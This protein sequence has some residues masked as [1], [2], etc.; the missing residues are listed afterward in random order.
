MKK[1]HLYCA[2]LFVLVFLSAKAQTAHESNNPDIVPV[3]PQSAI[4]Q[5][6][7]NHQVSE[8]TGIPEITIPLYE[9]ELKGMKIPI[10]LS[11]HASGV[12]AIQYDGD[13]GAGWSINVGGFKVMRTIYGLE[14]EKYQH[15]SYSNWQSNY[16]GINDLSSNRD[17]NEKDRQLDQFTYAW[18]TE[19]DRF[20]YILPSS[21]G[22]FIV[23]NGSDSD[24]IT[25]LIAESQQDKI[26]FTNGNGVYSFRDLVITDEQGVVYY[27]GDND[28]REYAP[29]PL[30]QTIGWP[31]LK[32]ITTYNEE[33]KF[34][35]KG[36]ESMLNMSRINSLIYQEAPFYTNYTGLMENPLQS[37]VPG[38]EF[39]T[40]NF[41]DYEYTGSQLISKITTPYCKVLFV[42]KG[43]PSENVYSDEIRYRWN[44]LITAVEVYNNNNE[45]VKSIN[46][47]YELAQKN[48]SNTHN[49][50]K[51]MTVSGIGQTSAK[52]VFQ[53]SYYPRNNYSYSDMWGYG[54]NSNYIDEFFKTYPPLLYKKYVVAAPDEFKYINQFSLPNGLSFGDRSVKNEPAAEYSLKRITFPTGGFTE[55]DYEPHVDD[56]Q[57]KIGGLRVKRIISKTSET[58]NPII[59]EFQYSKARFEVLLGNIDFLE[60]IYTLYFWTNYQASTV[61][62]PATAYRG[63]RTTNFHINPVLGEILSYRPIYEKVTTLQYDEGQRKYNGKT[64]SVYGNINFY[65]KRE[66]SGQARIL[67]FMGDN[68]IGQI[69]EGTFS[70]NFWT[71]PYLGY[72]PTL[73]SRTYYDN[74]D[75]IK[76][77]ETYNYSNVQKGTFDE[78]RVKER[79]KINNTAELG[80]YGEYDF[81][82]FRYDYI[83]YP[84]K[85]GFYRLDGKVT[86]DY[87]D[88]GEVR[89]AE[90]YQYN[91]NH[92]LIKKTIGN[93]LS[94]SYKYPVDFTE[95]VYKNMVSA[96]IL[97]PVIESVK[98]PDY[99]FNTESSRNKT[100]YEHRN[101]MYLPSS[102]LSKTPNV[103]Y[104]NEIT[105]DRHDAK[106]NI[107]QCTVLDGISIVYL[108]S[109]SGQYPIA[110]IKNATYSQ[111]TN[112]INETTLNLISNRVEPT[113]SDWLLVEGLRTNPS[114]ADAQVTTYRYKPL[115][116][117]LSI[118]GPSG[119]K[120]SF[121]YDALG[122]LICIK[123]H[124]G[125]V[126]EDY[127]YYLQNQ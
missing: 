42:R 77:T 84:L 39:P 65:E 105:F 93:L 18:D 71:N 127:Q 48:N 35:Y 103:D 23:L 82:N 56:N 60:D 74:E 43:N 50:L 100:T 106:G 30:F 11:Y 108:W 13:L 10:L 52:E 97:S 16:A 6:Y 76:R 3:T 2:V 123:D 83:H 79:I 81:I 9:L 109:Y 120:N 85:L 114:L 98:Y 45:L 94:E 7:L 112:I 73:M 126:I 117:V 22:N 44:Q 8:H 87:T 41:T 80:V 19:Y 28:N 116:G 78:L 110:E 4:Y 107:L 75:R 51:S 69:I 91:Q 68:S 1:L 5:K 61:G 55:Y 36:Y 102:I 101:G 86:T 96:N 40:V 14:D 20:S 121:E 57:I 122:R 32:M 38:A 95:T 25:A 58:S 26:A 70:R 124:Y 24:Q 89:L 125:N 67:P 92:Q 64:V 12:K 62:H 47:E 115:V 15:Y 29:M 27:L 31:L 59:T 90:S 111:V 118:T 46:F 66:M 88:N 104:R 34:E 33:V 17:R 53:F 49:L 54:G 21:S 72:S 63:T 119:L 37:F 113:A 99:P